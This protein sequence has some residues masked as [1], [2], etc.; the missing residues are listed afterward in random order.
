MND[1]W[2]KVGVGDPDDCW[3]FLGH[4]NAK[5]YGQLWLFG[6]LRTAHRV[7][8]ELRNGHVPRALCVCHSCDNP[9]C[10]N[11]SHLWQGTQKQ[12]GEDKAR[13]GRA[14]RSKLFPNLPR[15]IM[16]SP[17]ELRAYKAAY[18]RRWKAHNAALA[19]VIGGIEWIEG[20][21]KDRDGDDYNAFIKRLFDLAK[22]YD[23]INLTHAFSWVLSLRAGEVMPDF[24]D[25]EG[26]SQH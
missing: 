8:Y 25:E 23:L 17:G 15:P 1:I 13:K 4:T 19:N 16:P 20:D 7:I 12:N 14:R 5:G 3:H 18:F 24:D 26:V 9:S 6:R 22:G 2:K 11:P 10:C 21:G